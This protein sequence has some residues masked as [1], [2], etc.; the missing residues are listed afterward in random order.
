[1]YR[2]KIENLEKWQTKSDRKPLIVNGARQVGKTW[3]AKEF[4]RQRYEKTAHIDFQNNPRMKALFEQDLD[5][6]RILQGLKAES[7]IDIEPENTL[8][9]LDEVQEVPAALTALKYFYENM[10]G[11]HIIV[12]G[13]LLG[14]TVNQGISF[15]V[16]KVEFLSL[17]PLSF[18]EFLQALG[19]KQLLELLASGDT[20]LIAAF[21]DKYTDLLKTYYYVGGMPEAVKKYIETKS[22][23][24]VRIVQQNI[25]NSYDRDFGKH[26]PLNT[27]PRIRQVWQNIPAQLAKENKKYIY[28][29]LREGARAKDYELALRWLED[30]GL[31]YRVA[32]AETPKL[33]LKAYQNL[34]AFKIYLVDV[35]LLCAMTDLSAR[36]LLEGNHIFTEFKGALTEQYVL[37]ELKSG[38]EF[39]VAYWSKDEGSVA[40]V[41][42][43]IQNDDQIIPIEVKAE[44]NLQSK[45]LRAYAQKYSPKHAV[46][47]S[48]SN[49]RRDDWLTNIPLYMIGEIA[50]T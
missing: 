33:P 6:E 39:T 27:V 48:M 44:E 2:L 31:I 22:W 26:V 20:G 23:Q 17:Y 5:T 4:G 49:Y 46:R 19:E 40:E 28:G 3:L 36:T 11:Y 16:G 38:R 10:P 34:S 30:A 41:D 25:L 14:L 42:F 43:L 37:G 1:M 21:R 24:E 9:I 12:A 45:S 47:T 35:G 29:L 7:N 15:P 13:S 18:K 8:I 32:R 50:H